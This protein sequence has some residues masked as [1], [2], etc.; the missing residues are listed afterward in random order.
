MLSSTF[1][2]EFSFNVEATQT[3]TQIMEQ[4]NQDNA[5]IYINSS[6]ILNQN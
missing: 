4:I 1:L 5:I 2:A 6:R 3:A